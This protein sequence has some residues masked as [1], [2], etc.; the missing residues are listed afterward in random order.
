M[1]K[2]GI[3]M[4]R[5]F[6]YARKSTDT[7]DK[8]VLSIEAQ[9][10]ELKEF[11]RSRMPDTLI[12]EEFTESKT[13]KEP[14]R[15]IFNKMI[16][17]I[18]KGEAEGILAWHPDR[19]A[20][21]S[22]DGGQVIHFIDKGFI[23]YLS[24]PTYNFD[25]SAQGKF[26]LN[27]IF[28]QS[29]YYVDNL[30]ENVKRGI[31]QKLRR[32]EWS[33]Q[34]PFGYVNNY[35][36]RN[37]DIDQNVGPKIKLLYEEYLSGKYSLNE[38]KDFS[39]K[40]G[41]L[42]KRTGK[43]LQKSLIY[44][45]LNNPIYCGLIKSNGE[46]SEGRFEPIISKELFY[47]AKEIMKRKNRPQRIKHRFI[48]TGLIKC[49]HCG[50]MITA[51]THKGHT[52]Y[53]CTKKKEECD[54]KFIR[55]EYLV[56]QLNKK[57]KKVLIDDELQAYLENKLVEEKDNIN[58]S[59]KEAKKILDKSL[60]DIDL[61]INRLMDLYLEGQI[62][63]RDHANRKEKMLGEK[64]KIQQDLNQLENGRLF[65]LEPLELFINSLP[66]VKTIYE[67]TNLE[68][69]KDFIQNIGSNFNLRLENIR[70]SNVK[71]DNSS[72][73]EESISGGQNCRSGFGGG[74]PEK[75][76]RLNPPKTDSLASIAVSGKTDSPLGGGGRK[77]KT[78][79]R[80][81]FDFKEFWE[82]LAAE[83]QKIQKGG[84]ENDYCLLWFRL[85]D[86]VRPPFSESP[87]N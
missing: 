67:T 83:N 34:A 75:T 2:E 68:E 84:N 7:E 40:I 30:S 47:K 8:Q 45:I 43:P 20:R 74:L 81:D 12:V 33:S 77:P 70:F 41:L 62:S 51:E 15:P 44:K 72:Y 13:A 16:S 18:E 63:K 19:L 4:K 57:L 60:N 38:L 76:V 46:V 1:F 10:F 66:K 87:R 53:R 52:Y 71:N 26:M 39:V 25:N 73:L 27:I 61:K 31:R 49:N 37:I 35:K 86:A 78:K 36:T 9:L 56:E 32:G 6:L 42:G 23:K 24:F 29:K 85:K 69:K 65:W 50:C 5:F 54:T 28:G 3:I 79:M 14:G 82:I 21:N 48:F 64:Y 59:G 80:F 17:R 11:F 55:E 58:D 22:V